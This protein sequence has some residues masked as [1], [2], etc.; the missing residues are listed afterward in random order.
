MM[1][2]NDKRILAIGS[3]W[4]Q[5]SLIKEIKNQGY[6][7][8]ATHPNMNTTGFK[9]ADYY[10]VKDSRNISSHLNIAEAH[11]VD[12]V[13]TDNCDYSFY[14]A[15]IVAQNLGLPFNDIHAGILSND[16]YEQRIQ[17]EEAGILQPEYYQVKT[18]E[19]LKRACDSLGYPVIVKPIDS[20]GTFGITIVRSADKIEEAFVDGISKSHSRRLICEKYIEGTLITVDGFCFKNGHKS[21]AV[22]SR[23]FEK[24]PK[25]VTIE[26]IYPAELSTDIQ[27]KLR[28]NHEKVVDALGYKQGHTHGEYIISD[29]DDIYLVECTNRGGGVYTSSVILPHL[30]S[31]NLNKILL[32]QSLGIDN[33]EVEDF[34]LDFMK[35][36]IMLTFLDF[37][38][39]KVIKSINIDEVR[40]LPYVIRFRSIFGE[41][42]MVE[43]VENCASRHSMLVIEGKTNTEVRNNLNDFKSKLKIEYHVI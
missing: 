20:R 27:K 5:Y 8:V 11:N 2:S 36:S 18:L 37:E 4:E 3:G 9:I 7:V 30:T 10:Y 33:Y 32:D 38:V 24:G 26:I 13:I 16:K 40:S 19:S 43:S 6:E 22:A 23:E 39:N 31:I 17:C 35:K 1:T 29:N 15:T 25:P 42:D 28:K 14:T 21:L 41:N 34:G 12:G